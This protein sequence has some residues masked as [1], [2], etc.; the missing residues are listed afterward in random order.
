MDTL[1]FA[2]DKEVGLLERTQTGTGGRSKLQTERPPAGDLTHFLLAVKRQCYSNSTAYALS[3]AKVSTLWA[4]QRN[5]KGLTSAAA[6]SVKYF[7]NTLRVVVAYFSSLSCRLHCHHCHLHGFLPRNINIA[8]QQQWSC[9]KF[10]FAKVLSDISAMTSQHQ[11]WAADKW[12]A[13][14][15]QALSECSMQ[16][17]IQAVM[18][19]MRFKGPVSNIFARFIYFYIGKSLTYCL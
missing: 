14:C 19:N 2:I 6:E 10:L 3:Q 18:A 9:R 17:W 16:K 11:C 5:S 12:R 8:L 4:K 15:Y 7:T 13:L 1:E